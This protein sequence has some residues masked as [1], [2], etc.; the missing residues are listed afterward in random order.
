MRALEPSAISL[1]PVAAAIRQARRCARSCSASPPS[2]S[3]TF[4]FS[5]STR[6]ALRT[7]CGSACGAAGTGSG[8]A[9]HAA[10]VPGGVGRQDQRRDAP[11]A[12]RAAC[13]AAAASRA[14]LARPLRGAHPG[15]DAARPAFGV[16]GQRRVERA[17]IGRL[18]ADD[19]DDAGAGAPRV[20][21]VG[22]PVREARARNAAAW[23]RACRAI[24]AVAV[25]RAGDHVLLQAEHAAHAGD[26]VERRDEMHL[27][28][29]GIGEAGIH[30][31]GEQRVDQAFGAVHRRLSGSARG[32]VTAGS[33]GA[34][35]EDDTHSGGEDQAESDHVHGG[36]NSPRERPEFA[37]PNRRR[38]ADLRMMVTA[39]ASNLWR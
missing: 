2:R 5:R 34:G 24:A 13:T 18:V 38:A 14:D 12:V 3:S 23:R 39:N 31:A 32:G 8:A 10:L 33:A 17:V 36:G 11:G 19:V 21:Q 28:G 15:R 20:V 25:G 7:A 22:Q 16:R 1:A 26:A 35:L 27:A 29:A 6:A 30:A 9:D 4:F 37:P